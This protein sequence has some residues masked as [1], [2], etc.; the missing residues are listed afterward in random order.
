[1]LDAGQGGELCPSCAVAAPSVV[2]PMHDPQPAS[3]L[4]LLWA[5]VAWGVSG[6]FLLLLEMAYRLYLIGTNQKVP[7]IQPNFLIIV[8]TLALTLVMHIAGFFAA[9]LAVTRLGKR[10]FW[11]TL[12]WG[13]H[14]QFRWVHAVGL[15]LL[16]FG[17]AILAERFLPHK[18]TELEK[19]LKMG[20]S[21][22][23]MVAALAVLSAPLIEEIIYRGVVYA[24]VEGLWGKAAAVV[25]VT[26]LFALVH[27][28]QYWGSYAAIA[29]ICSLSLVLT[30][31]RAW[32]DRL[33]PCVAT[34]LVYNGIQAFLLLAASKSAS[35]SE[36]TDAAM[37]ILTQLFRLG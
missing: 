7:E 9:Y 32:T 8:V 3:Y 34:H 6:G 23:I 33:A 21:V 24:S 22:R 4:D 30:L 26:A 12:K 5:I 18:E 31:L 29:A 35:T 10:P 14:S 16:M 19:F 36:T 2:E 27:V 28:P 37:A 11:K 17:V 13:W 1:M 15:A 20:F 25:T